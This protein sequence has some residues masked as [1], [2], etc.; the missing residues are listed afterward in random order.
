MDIT[1]LE[2]KSYNCHRSLKLFLPSEFVVSSDVISLLCP[3]VDFT[4]R[5]F[6]SYKSKHGQTWA[7]L[8]ML[9][10]LKVNKTAEYFSQMT[11]P[12]NV[13]AIKYSFIFFFL[14]YCGGG[15]DVSAPAL[16]SK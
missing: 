10:H 1:G 7:I 9:S 8:Q 16:L 5:M 4:S 14:Y 12:S 2:S 13:K 6:I 11:L 3:S 15:V